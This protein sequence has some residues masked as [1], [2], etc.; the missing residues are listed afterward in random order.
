M[1]RKE[2]SWEKNR[3]RIAQQTWGWRHK[4]RTNGKNARKQGIQKHEE[5]KHP[6][7]SIHQFNQS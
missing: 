2:G 7:F 6:A 3:E 4:K 5:M 1:D